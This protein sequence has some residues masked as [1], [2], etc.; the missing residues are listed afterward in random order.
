MLGDVVGSARNVRVRGERDERACSYRIDVVVIPFGDGS[1]PSQ[2]VVSN[3]MTASSGVR[4]SASASLAV[5]RE[6]RIEPLGEPPPAVS[7]R[8]GLRRTPRRGEGEENRRERGHERFVEV[9]AAVTRE[10]WP[11]SKQKY[12]KVMNDALRATSKK[13]LF[14]LCY[15][16][17]GP[18]PGA[19]PQGHGGGHRPS[20]GAVYVSPTPTPWLDPRRRVGRGGG[21]APMQPWWYAPVRQ[22]SAATRTADDAP[23]GH[24]RASPAPRS[25]L[26][27]SFCP[28]RGAKTRPAQPQRTG[29]RRSRDGHAARRSACAAWAP[30]THPPDRSTLT[31]SAP[32]ALG[33]LPAAPPSP[34]FACFESGTRDS[35]ACAGRRFRR[36]AHEGRGR[37]GRAYG[38]SCGRNPTGT[39]RARG[40]RGPHP[41][42]A[43]EMERWMSRSC[44]SVRTAT[45]RREKRN[46][47]L[48]E[49]G[50]EARADAR[51]STPVRAQ[52]RAP[53]RP[54]RF[55]GRRLG[56]RDATGGW[57]ATGIRRL[58]K[59]TERR[60]RTRA[61]GAPRAARDA[62][63][64]RTSRRTARTT[65]RGGGDRGGERELC[66]FTGTRSLAR[67]V[68]QRRRW[69][70]S[71]DG[72]NRR[73]TSAKSSRSFTDG[74]TCAPATTHTARE[75][76]A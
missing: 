57:P 43:A 25:S 51:Q 50:G 49:V 55:Q 53:G 46:R 12:T 38:P 18:I 37:S 10:N 62:D 40:R 22:K 3:L 5:Q 36:A 71:D 2:E 15:L 34:T 6:I 11:S 70:R 52:R 69:A 26:T 68:R 28:T 66:R 16:L 45:S 8:R 75:S 41:E 30:L 74:R 13:K 58:R 72:R 31:P 60:K 76:L 61:G 23:V 14:P 9:L 29:P 39:E 35:R 48:G 54:G 24:P 73:K 44:G 64:R 63:A 19:W 33:R 65:I 59:R 47:T 21:Q 1:V 17:D 27:R 4:E 42:A 67:R 7:W 32:S 20:A 56:G